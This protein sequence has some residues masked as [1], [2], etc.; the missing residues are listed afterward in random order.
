MFIKAIKPQSKIAMQR[1]KFTKSK[2]F[3]YTDGT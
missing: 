3:V 1:H 2:I